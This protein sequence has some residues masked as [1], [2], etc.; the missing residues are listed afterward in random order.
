MLTNVETI[1]VKTVEP[2][3]IRKE[4]TNANA[5]KDIQAITVNK[6]LLQ[7]TISVT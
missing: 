2:A 3:L 7:Y 5:F 1:L 6:V 4:V